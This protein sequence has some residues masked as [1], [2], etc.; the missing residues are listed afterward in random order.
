MTTIT[1]ELG[2]RSYPIHIGEGLVASLPELLRPLGISGWTGLVSNGAIHQLYG[3]AVE[4]ALTAV[5]S[6][7]FTALIPDDEKAKELPTISQLYDSLLEAGLERTSTL[8]ALGGGVIGDVTGFVAATLFRGISYLQLPTTLL[9]MVDSSIGGKTGVN[10]PRGKNLIGAFHQPRAVFIDP[11]LVRT[12]PRR[13]LTSACAEI[14]KYAAISNSGFLQQLAEGIRSLVNLTDLPLLENAIIQSCRIK[15]RVVSGDER[16]SDQ[17]RILNFGHTLGHALEAS[18]GYGNL[19]H[20]EA[21]AMGMVAAAHIS[22]R[23]TGLSTAE[24]ELLA[25]PI[26]LLDLPKLPTLNKAA[27]RQHLRHDKKVRSGV[28]HFVLLE[29]IGQPVIS[30]RVTDTHIT[31]ALEEL[32]RRFG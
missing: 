5:G 29:A 26:S 28:T 14:I 16:E 8:V 1:V 15:A 30:D 4:S 7:V 24:M 32:Q 3:E 12:L 22:T 17:R 31:E 23:V 9:A 11:A 2:S 27:F 21:V 19:R 13:E 25:S 20:G 18:A 10:H 6:Q